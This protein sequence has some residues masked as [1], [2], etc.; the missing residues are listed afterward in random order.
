MNSNQIRRFL[1]GCKCFIGVYPRD[2]LPVIKTLPCALVA[3]TDD[4]K[5]PG[6]HWVAMYFSRT[7]TEYFDSFGLPPYHEDLINYV[8]VMSLVILVISMQYC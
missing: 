6:E 2:Q 7:K 4:S 3:N 5:N 8:Y 1:K